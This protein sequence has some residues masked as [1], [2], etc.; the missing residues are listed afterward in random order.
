MV[1]NTQVN[2]FG[3]M[4]YRFLTYLSILIDFNI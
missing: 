2:A 4:N 3:H 1:K